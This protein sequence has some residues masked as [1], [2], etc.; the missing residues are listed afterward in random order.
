M[1]RSRASPP[2]AL[3]WADAKKDSRELARG[4][5][6]ACLLARWLFSLH[7][8]ELRLR[9]KTNSPTSSRSSEREGGIQFAR[10]LASCAAPKPLQGLRVKLQPANVAPNWLER[11][12]MRTIHALLGPA[13]ERVQT[14]RAFAR[15]RYWIPWKWRLDK[16]S[17]EPLQT[18]LWSSGA[19]RS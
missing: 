12:N 8:I 2:H 7:Q 6:F 1:E 5:L 10:R 11:A 13:A 15:N 18:S 3:E 14:S 9:F 4:R 19:T 17:P 16:C